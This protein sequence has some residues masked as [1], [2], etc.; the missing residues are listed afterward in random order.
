MTI[1][2]AENMLSGDRIVCADKIRNVVSAF[3]LENQVYEAAFDKKKVRNVRAGFKDI[4]EL[5]VGKSSNVSKIISDFQI[6]VHDGK[7]Y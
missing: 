3:E 1:A 2:L 7:N 5:F 6:C 4:L